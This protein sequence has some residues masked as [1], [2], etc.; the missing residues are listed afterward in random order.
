MMAS[1]RY[2]IAFLIDGLSMGGAERLMVPILKH[3][4]RD[5]FE[6]RVC[7]FQT[8]EGN[9]MA[10]S[11]QA[12]DVP[13][14]SLEINRLRDVSA[15]PRL[16]RYLKEN[17]VKLVHTQLEFANILGN[18]AAKF[19]RLPSVCTVHVLPPEEVKLKTKFHQRAEWTSLRMFCDRIVSVSEE[20]R[21]YHLD[22]AGFSPEKITTIYNG[23]DLM[24][25]R[26]SGRADRNA[27]RRELGIPGNANL[28]TTV[29]VLRQPKGIEFMIRAL[30]AVLAADPLAYYL[31]V[32]SGP[33]H[34]VLIEE[35]AKV[36]VKDRVIFAGL[37][38][39]VPDLLAASDLFVLPTLTEALPTVLAEA[40]A[41]GLPIVASAV[42][43]V[44]EMVTNGV[45]G[46]LVSPGVP[47][48]LSDACI[49][50]LSSPEKRKSMGGRG[51]EIVDEKFSIARQVGQMRE[52]YL[53]LLSRHE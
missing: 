37:R 25:F 9:P 45:N 35:V 4:S 40:M 50:L 26:K 30:P 7:V 34:D 46:R 51:L 5:D 17:N 3:L 15:L 1:K 27:I 28:M 18:I 48:E 6:P 10:E 11:I 36:G 19:M 43:G 39:D 2:T 29:A 44:P 53:D 24:E 32:G 49:D 23:I 33:H 13:V 47:A 21:T 12:L 31:V 16:T 8:K 14:D 41:V 22:I 52:L 42:G 38:K 20:A